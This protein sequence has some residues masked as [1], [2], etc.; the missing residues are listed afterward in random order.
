MGNER[1]TWNPISLL[2]LS[3]IKLIISIKDTAIFWEIIKKETD[4][5]NINK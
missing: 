3:F 4:M 1:Y 2:S 5:M